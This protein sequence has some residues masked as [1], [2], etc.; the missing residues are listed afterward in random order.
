MIQRMSILLLI[1][2]ILALTPVH[3]ALAKDRIEGVWYNQEKSAKIEIYLAKDQKYWG[4]IIWLKEPMRDGK[5]KLDDKNQNPS[6]RQ[7]PIL[8][9]AILKRFVKTD[10][11]NYEDGEIYDPKNGKTYSCIIKFANENE[12]NI[13]GYIGISLIGRTTAWTRAD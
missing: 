13:R 9:M 12:L 8:G 11:G 1:S 4:K 3:Q 7:R 6:L 2:T 10:E 5:P